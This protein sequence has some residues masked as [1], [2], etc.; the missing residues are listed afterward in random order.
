MGSNSSILLRN[1]KYVLIFT[2]N[3]AKLARLFVETWFVSYGMSIFYSSLS[4]I[5]YFEDVTT[6]GRAIAAGGAA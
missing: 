4:S 1:N 2:N 3:V 6:L 5:K